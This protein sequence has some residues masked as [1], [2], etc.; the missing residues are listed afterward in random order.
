M[1]IDAISACVRA[2]S[3][4][5]ML[6]AAGMAMFLVMLGRFLE[7][8]AVDIGR[9]GF[10]S[11]VAGVVLVAVHYLLEAGRMAGAWNGVLDSGLQRLV[12]DSPLSAAAGLRL[13]GMLAIA[14]TIRR[15]AGLAKLAGLIGAGCVVLS[16]AFVGHTADETR[17]RWL[18]AV[19]VLHLLAVA[20]WFGGLVP[21]YRVSRLESGSCAGHIVAQFSRLATWIVPALFVFGLVLSV[22]IVGRIGALAEPYGRLLLTKV[23]GFSLLMALAVAN[24]WRY[25]PQLEHSVDANAAFRRSVAAEYVLICGVLAVTAVMTT[26]F[27]PSE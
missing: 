4:I 20:F 9:V 25:G 21:L 19:L 17:G 10:G 13:L 3:F 8:S 15:H 2:L 23:A 1:T 7:R 18:G 27:S 22:V 16:F 5:A 12:L 26:F 24:K 6:Q 11:A 14:S